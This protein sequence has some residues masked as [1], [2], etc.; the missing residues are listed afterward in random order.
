MK[1]TT[2]AEQDCVENR[3]WK[4]CSPG[5]LQ[6]VASTQLGRNRRRHLL[7][8]IA[9]ISALAAV[10]G[11]SAVGYA[12]SK[13]RSNSRRNTNPLGALGCISVMDMMPNYLDGE[14]DKLVSEQVTTHLLKCTKCRRMYTSMCG[15]REARLRNP[16]AKTTPQ[17]PQ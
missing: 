11:G 5:V 8:L 16:A 9:G 4:P 7:G 17:K 6:Q 13:S 2:D 10:G 15:E 1:K 12:L 3:Q 14:L